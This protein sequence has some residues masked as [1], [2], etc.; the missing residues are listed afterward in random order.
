M[1]NKPRS[2]LNEWWSGLNKKAVIGAAEREI[3]F[4]LREMAAG[5]TLVAEEVNCSFNHPIYSIEALT[6][7]EN[8][9]ITLRCIGNVVAPKLTVNDLPIRD[10]R[11]GD[12]AVM[13]YS[14]RA[15]RVRVEVFN[16]L[17]AK[18]K[19]NAGGNS[20]SHSCSS[21]SVRVYDSYLAACR[22]MANSYT[23]MGLLILGMAGRS[24]TQQLL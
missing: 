5:D 3:E 15:M 10:G 19:M 9:A 16:E 8:A 20:G 2:K 7:Y 6:R 13:S 14:S 24:Y 21:R 22:R 17:A 12:E 11:M 23:N 4:A 18:K 1:K